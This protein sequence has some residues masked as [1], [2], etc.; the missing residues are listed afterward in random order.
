MNPTVAWLSK[1]PASPNESCRRRAALRQT[2]LTKPPGALGRLEELAIRLA[3]L[4]GTE[5]PRV[6]KVQITLFAAD[7]GV[8]NEGVSAFPQAVT[9]EMVKNFVR[10]GAAI[11]V[12]ARELG[13][14]LEIVNLGTASEQESLEGVSSLTLGPG[15]ANFCHGPAMD[16]SQLEQAL[17]AGKQ[18]AER[19]SENGTQLFIGGEMGIGNSTSATALACMLLGSDPVQLTGPGTGLDTRGVKRKT[20][21]IRRALSL[22]AD[23]CSTPLETLRRLG[24]FEIVAL[25]GAYVTC[26]QL[27]L[28][29]LVDGFISSAAA[30][31][32]SRLSPGT[33]A[34]FLFSHVSAEPGHL[35]ILNALR[36]SPLLDLAMRLGEGSGAAVAVPLLRLACTLHNGMATFTEAGIPEKSG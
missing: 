22:H 32:A 20:E 14:S 31:A 29:V 4:Q 33:E 36:G 26:A 17:Q 15:T 30:L 7:H 35:L 8:A 10:G 2:M 1:N 5:R 9:A 16:Q 23:H 28:P 13:A 27:G 11:S 3:A 6:D 21:V 24:G 25:C 12:L 19:A 34:W 18:A